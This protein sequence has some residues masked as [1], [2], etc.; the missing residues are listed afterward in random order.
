VS[1]L[2]ALPNVGCKI[3]GLL[4]EA[5]PKEWSR[6][7]ILRYARHV[8]TS[9]GKD[10]VIF[11]S[12]WPVVTLADRSMEWYSLAQELTGGWTSEE[13]GRFFSGNARKFYRM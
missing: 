3:S 4:T 13:R 9:F 6:E 2:A 5:D 8:V 7:E 10:R 12:D 1:E 11:G